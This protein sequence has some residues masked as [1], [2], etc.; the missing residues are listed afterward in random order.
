MSK[1]ATTPAVE[2]PSFLRELFRAELYKR[3]QG[4]LARQATFGAVA[5]GFALG[6]WSLQTYLLGSSL[7]VGA[8][9]GLSLAV[10][11]GGCWLA[12][13]LVNFPRFADFLIAVEVEMTK[14]TWPTRSELVRSSIVVIG[15]IFG[16][17]AVLLVFDYVWAV[18]LRFVGVI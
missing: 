4:K 3:T 16:L 7:P 15:L 18:L 10:L 12:F 2:S 13:R 9:Y 5:I 14:V 8:Q 1:E 11:V 6:A 17:S